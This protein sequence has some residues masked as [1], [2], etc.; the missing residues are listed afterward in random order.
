MRA[1]YRRWARAGTGRG[2]PPPGAPGPAGRAR[3]GTPR[4]HP[5]CAATARWATV[6]SGRTPP[7]GEVNEMSDS[8]PNRPAL[9]WTSGAVFAVA[10]SAALATAGLAA[11]LVNVFERKQEA[12]NP[13]FRVVE[14]RDDSVDPA[15]WGKTFP[16]QYDAYLRTVD[17]QRTRFGGSE[18][19]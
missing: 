16:M 15:M 13:F 2:A 7:P 12:R 17:Q 6:S 4:A 14:L 1:S 11:L 9:G 8:T 10:G 5:A 19:A 18:G 3:A